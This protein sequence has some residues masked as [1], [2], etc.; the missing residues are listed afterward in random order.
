MYVCMYVCMLCG[1][2]PG[3]LHSSEEMVVSERKFRTHTH[4]YTYTHTNIHMYTHTCIDIHAHKHTH[5]RTRTPTPTPTST[6]IVALWSSLSR[7]VFSLSTRDP[8]CSLKTLQAST[9]FSGL[10]RAYKN[11]AR[12]IG[13]GSARTHTHTHTNSSRER[14]TSDM[15]EKTRKSESGKTF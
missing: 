4:T 10:H 2:V 9:A 14:R 15:L 3:S 12:V 1:C 5:T 13:N 11:A 7:A 6:Q 8:L